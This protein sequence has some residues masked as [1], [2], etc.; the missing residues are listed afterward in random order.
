[1]RPP[2][3]LTYID[4]V[5][6]HGSIRKAAEAL[7]MASSALNRRIL[8]LEEDLGCGLFERLPRGV[9]PTAAGELFIDYVRRAISDLETVTSRIE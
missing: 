1:M 6:R 9:R 7:H 8:D 3:I 5:A 2:R 4:A